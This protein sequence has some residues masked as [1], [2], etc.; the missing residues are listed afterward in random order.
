MDLR[1]YYLAL[2]HSNKDQDKEHN[3]REGRIL[4]EE[5]EYIF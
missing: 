1:F 4:S 5:A 3:T 2:L